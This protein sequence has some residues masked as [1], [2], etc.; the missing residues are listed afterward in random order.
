MTDKAGLNSQ[1][2]QV[3]VHLHPAQ[4]REA[5]SIE[6][7]DGLG[8]SPKALSPKWL[9]DAR[10]CELFDQIT[11]L[12][13]Y[14][15]T[16]A[17]RSILDSYASEIQQLSGANTLIELGS[18]TSE[19]TRLLLAAFNDAQSLDRFLAFDVAEATLRGAVSSIQADYPETEVA[20]IVGD[21]TQHLSVLP[22]VGTR[23]VAF[24]GGTIGNFDA[25]QRKSFLA[26]LAQI[27]N[28][29]ESILLGTDLIKDRS[30]LI[31]AYDDSSG[32][33]AA[34]NKNLLSVLNTELGA[35]FN[36]DAFEHVA[37]FNE[38]DS[39]IEMRLR[40]TCDQQV[41]IRDLNLNIDFAAGEDLL[42]EISTK[43]TL[44]QA[45]E[46]LCAAGFNTLHYWTDPAQDFALWLAIR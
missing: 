1:H 23:M 28:P 16:R 35:E 43:F 29:G 26:S 9:Y 4:A 10:G 36:L 31:A 42:S 32:V 40:S 25:T 33:T 46:E 19:K 34:F 17:E 30:R 45:R 12:A 21:F 18:G 38:S 8:S 11:Q 7:A 39:C 15:P 13:E 22:T 37:L 3:S 41:V 5:L 6:V 24:L 20:G 27:L 14:Y 2:G 44:Q